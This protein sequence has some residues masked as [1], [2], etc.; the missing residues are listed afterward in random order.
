MKFNVTPI[1]DIV[2]LLIIFFLIV[3]R[4]I[5]AENFKVNVPDDCKFAEKAGGEGL[6]KT[7]VTVMRNASQDID[8]AV[9]SE[10]IPAVKSAELAE[11]ISRQIDIQLED[12]PPQQRIVTLRV[13]KGIS[14]GQARHALAAIAASSAVN[15]EIAALKNDSK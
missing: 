3:S 5:E 14:F 13:D 7:T 15:I 2:F 11:T 10:K 4:F 1:I 12:L 9:G 8:F 6:E